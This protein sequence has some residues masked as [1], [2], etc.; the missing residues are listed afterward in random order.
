M[1]G[2]RKKLG[3]VSGKMKIIKENTA[4]LM[5]QKAS[6]LKAVGI[7]H[8]QV[9]KILEQNIWFITINPITKGVVFYL[10]FF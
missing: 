3:N 9:S 6:V 1:E 5:G 4:I 8:A 7:V 2:I 10:S